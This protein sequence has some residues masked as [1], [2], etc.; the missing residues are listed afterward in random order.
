[1]VGL[2]I[3]APVIVALAIPVSVVVASLYVYYAKICRAKGIFLIGT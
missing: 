2:V 3:A 1:V